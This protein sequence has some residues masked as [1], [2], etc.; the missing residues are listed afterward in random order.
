M[1][2]V[3]LYLYI[4]I[5][6]ILVQYCNYYA[7]KGHIA[8]CFYMI[9]QLDQYPCKLTSAIF[10]NFPKFTYDITYSDLFHLMK[11]SSMHYLSPFL[12]YVLTPREKI[13]IK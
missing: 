4:Y 11:A 5:A 3:S 9:R 1:D 12:K 2:N 6:L 8:T 13:N 7:H 10:S